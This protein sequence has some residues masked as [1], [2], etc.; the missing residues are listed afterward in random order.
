MKK[1][2]TAIL[3][4]MLSHFVSYAQSRN[5]TEA[6]INSADQAKLTKE[7][8]NAPYIFEGTIIETKSYQS[9]K[10]YTAQIIKIHKVFKGNIMCGTVKIISEGG[11][12]PEKLG[13]VL[14]PGFGTMTKG[15]SG[16]FLCRTN[17]LPDS[18]V[19][20]TKP[21]NNIVLQ[22]NNMIV[23]DIDDYSINF[24]TLTWSL[25]KQIY[26][27][28]IQE[29]DIQIRKCDSVN[30]QKYRDSLAEAHHKKYKGW[31]KKLRSLNHSTDTSK[32]NTPA[33]PGSAQ[34]KTKGPNNGTGLFFS[35]GPPT[36]TS[37]GGLQY[38]LT[39]TSTDSLNTALD[40]D[41][42]LEQEDPDD[43]FYLDS[44]NIFLH[45]SDSAFSGAHVSVSW[46]LD[47]AAYSNYGVSTSGSEYEIYAVDND[48]STMVTLTTTPT[49]ICH[50][51]VS[52]PCDILPWM[53]LDFTNMQGGTEVLYPSTY[54]KEMKIDST[55]V[56]DDDGDTISWDYT[57]S[58]ETLPITY[59][60]TPDVDTLGSFNQMGC[61]PGITSFTPN[62]IPAGLNDTMKIFGYNF[63]TQGDSSK[64]KFDN[65][66]KPFEQYRAIDNADIISWNNNEIDL[67]LPSYVIR[68][69]SPVPGTGYV[70]VINSQNIGGKSSSKVKIPYAIQNSITY[71]HPTTKY[72][73]DMAGMNMDSG[74]TVQID[75]GY[76]Y[77]HDSVAACIQGALREWSCVTGVNWRRG[78]DTT[79]ASIST[80]SAVCYIHFGVIDT[81]TC[82]QTALHTA[83]C[84]VADKV[85]SFGFD[86]NIDTV[87]HHYFYDPTGLQWQPAGYYDFYEIILHELGHAHTLAHVNDTNSIMYYGVSNTSTAP[88]DR[89]LYL[90]SDSGSTIIGG[91]VAMGFAK[92]DVS[93]TSCYPNMEPLTVEYCNLLPGPLHIN[94]ITLSSICTNNTI[95]L[96]PSVSGGIPYPPTRT[97]KNPYYLY[98]WTP[99]YENTANIDTY[100][101]HNTSDTPYVYNWNYNGYSGKYR[102]I[103]YQLTVTDNSKP[104]QTA[105]SII[106]AFLTG[107]STL[108]DS[109]IYAMHDGP[110]DI[111]QEPDVQCLADPEHSQDIW[112]RWVND[113]SPVYQEPQYAVDDSTGL[114][115]PDYAYIRIWN[116]GCKRPN[117]ATADSSFLHVYWTFAAFSERWRSDWIGQTK[118][119]GNV[120]GKEI[121]PHKGIKLGGLAPGR[122]TVIAI[123]WYPPSP[124]AI[125]TY[126]YTQLCMLA[127]IIKPGCADSGLN[128]KDTEEYQKPYAP[129]SGFYKIDSGS[130]F[131]NV[132]NH[133]NIATHNMHVF[134]IGKNVVTMVQP[135]FVNH[136]GMN[137]YVN[138]HFVVEPAESD[139]GFDT[140][141]VIKI[142]P[143]PIVFNRWVETGG[144]YYGNIWPNAVDSSFVVTGNNAWIYNIPING[145]DTPMV[146][147]KFQLTDTSSALPPLHYLYTLTQYQQ[148]T[149][150][151]MA[152]TGAFDY[153][154]NVNT[155]DH[156]DTTT[157]DTTRE[158]YGYAI[159]LTNPLMVT[160][161]TTL[162]PITVS[163]FLNFTTDID[164][165]ILDFADIVRADCSFSNV[166]GLVSVP[167]DIT[168]LPDGLY[169]AVAHEYADVALY[170]QFLKITPNPVIVYPNPTTGVFNVSTSLTYGGNIQTKVYDL[171]GDLLMQSPAYL[172]GGSGI[173]TY[174][175]DLSGYT[176]GDYIAVT[177]LDGNIINSTIEA[178]ICSGGSPSP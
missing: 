2:L 4:L 149:P 1:I 158:Y 134:E 128:P 96:M 28:I 70:V 102:V 47:M 113:G 5:P 29:T 95:R 26:N 101:T 60:E 27:R 165:Q 139:S 94:G 62:S 91:N 90:S 177:I 48:L 151:S 155:A 40:F 73:I 31:D 172:Y 81:N 136:G 76:S 137:G 109:A 117:T 119:N 173:F 66:N 32:I 18:P 46:D 153:D 61:N 174:S 110:L 12:G 35:P 37:P 161:D 84:G 23:Y 112:N 30:F 53:Y 160:P 154:I 124:L 87:Y 78:A 25:Y 156:T 157:C 11:W 103:R 83:R 148:I 22:I 80:S 171:Y 138:W 52:L 44:A 106:A 141:G 17:S 69:P 152:V 68:S 107:D 132:V 65:A 108:A 45:L 86:I 99:L 159:G 123:K 163:N 88:N 127:R 167:F 150:D 122:D 19:I 146:Y 10:A 71:S 24:E 3:F 43:T 100:G 144:T 116:I 114:E 6:Q 92:T 147:V 74:Y 51:H 85:T 36:L 93:A 21:D 130:T 67:I 175:F 166:S 50:V 97:H 135:I 64:V 49:L 104:F 7:I 41:I 176:D 162:G 140:V 82:A 77:R 34:P 20:V 57:Y 13:G 125:P 14:Q 58:H 79:I 75:S 39:L 38:L 63:G 9:G 145:L 15:T 111:F 164:F 98:T 121:T 16:V 178:K 118:L 55:A 33:T 168:S 72:R 142:Y 59:P 115:K 120:D 105:T 8:K 170:Q 129:T 133:C 126:E 169:T 89:H 131:N 143:G 42:S 54:V 56:T